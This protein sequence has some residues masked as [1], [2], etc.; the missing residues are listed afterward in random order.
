MRERKVQQ[1]E[2][3]EPV[4]HEA[5]PFFSSK[6]KDRK[7]RET[8]KIG[9]MRDFEVQQLQR[10]EPE[11]GQRRFKKQKWPKPRRESGRDWQMCSKFARQRYSSCP[12][13]SG[14]MAPTVDR[15]K[16]VT[17]SCPAPR[18]R[19]VPRRVQ[20]FVPGGYKIASAHLMEVTLTPHARR[21]SR[22]V[23]RPR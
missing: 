11:V 19:L 16:K 1:L 10:L 23:A 7:D 18:P 14:S 5:G 8:G 2:R 20:K 15:N 17:S 13:A 21:R 4:L 22:P 12:R 6:M 9:V 3:P